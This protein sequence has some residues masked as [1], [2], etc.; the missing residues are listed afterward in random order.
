[1]YGSRVFA[2]ENVLLDAEL[3]SLVCHLLEDVPAEQDD[4]AVEVIEA[5]GPGGHYLA[6]THTRAH[7][8][9]LWM[10]RFFDRDA[11]E[12]WEA[13]GRPEARDR[14]HERVATILAENEPEPLPEDVERELRE[15]T[16]RHEREGADHG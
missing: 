16:E 15:M 14:A 1:V 2:F 10:P 8:R 3:F 12:D 13:A 7:M 9:E 5:V 11:W 6:E 4:L